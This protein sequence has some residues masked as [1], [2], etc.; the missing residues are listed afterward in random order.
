MTTEPDTTEAGIFN[1]PPRLDT[2]TAPELREDLIAQRGLN[3]T[4]NAEDVTHLGA[5]CLAVLI[6]A[7]NTWREDEKTLTLGAASA[8]FSTGLSRMGCP[9][10]LVT[11]E[12]A[13]A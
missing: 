10:T 4:L 2:D 8:A 1:L 3:L 7:A 6:A 12:E 5:R 9:T 13:P 11:T